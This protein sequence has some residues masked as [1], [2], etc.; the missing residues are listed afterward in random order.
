MFDYDVILVIYKN[1]GYEL[2]NYE[3]LE[4]VLDMLVQYFEWI[5]RV[6]LI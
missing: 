6:I 3:D 4:L 5:E 2:V 1:G